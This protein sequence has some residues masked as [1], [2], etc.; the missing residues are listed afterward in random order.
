MPSGPATDQ[1]PQGL[2][3]SGPQPNSSVDTTIS[4]STGGSSVAGIGST[5]TG[6]TSSTAEVHAQRAF[7]G[8]AQD[9]REQATDFGASVHPQSTGDDA[10][11]RG[12]DGDEAA[13]L[14]QQRAGAAA[15]DA[16]V[17]G[18]CFHSALS[19]LAYMWLL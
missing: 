16:Q 14:G 3:P 17:T 18:K 8:D 6:Q 1:G 5:A 4:N 19:T 15:A 2:P 10:A 7:A 11:Q 12:S 13:T 9:E